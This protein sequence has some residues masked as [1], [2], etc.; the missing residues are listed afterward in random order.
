MYILHAVIFSLYEPNLTRPECFQDKEN[1]VK[2]KGERTSQNVVFI[3]FR[4]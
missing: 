2:Y 1:L 3:V 4:N